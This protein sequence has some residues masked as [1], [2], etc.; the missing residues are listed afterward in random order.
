MPA[1]ESKDNPENAVV[2]Q[3]FGNRLQVVLKQLTPKQRQVFEMAVIRKEP[4][5]DIARETGWSL[6]DVKVNVYRA[7]RRVTEAMGDLL[8]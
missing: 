8:P 4:Y 6:S 2:F 1:G 3:N 5:A 7:R